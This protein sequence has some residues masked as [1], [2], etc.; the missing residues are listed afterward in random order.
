MA[1]TFGLIEKL[2]LSAF[3]SAWAPFYYASIREPDAPR[4][5]RTVTTYGVAILALLTAGLSAVGTDAMAAMTHGRLLAPEDPRWSEVSTVITWTAIGVFLQG[6]YLLTSIGLNITKQTQ[7]Y[8]AA[9]I[10]AAVTNVAL[11]IFLIPRHGIVGAAWANGA[12]YALQAV[13]GCIF[14]QRF[15][16]I[17][18]EWGRL[19]QV[20]GASTIA[21]RR[22]APALGALGHDQLAI[23][24]RAAARRVAARYDGGRGLRAPPSDHGLLPCG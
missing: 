24:A 3:E 16:A 21:P 12:A 19:A 17:D 8:P 11:N 6:F 23:V 18:Y 1:V 4:I 7:F 13:L 15:Y 9:T 20:C 2:F 5:F 14:S 10:S 22:A